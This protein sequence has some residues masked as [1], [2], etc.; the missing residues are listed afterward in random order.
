MPKVGRQALYDPVATMQLPPVKVVVAMGD[1]D[2]TIKVRL[3]PQ[4]LA[5]FMPIN[6]SSTALKAR[7]LL[8]SR[9]VIRPNSPQTST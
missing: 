2:V 5:P 7:L 4:H 8:D 1:E 6:P 9:I 3:N